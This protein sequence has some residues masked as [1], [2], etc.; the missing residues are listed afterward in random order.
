EKPLQF[1]MANGPLQTTV[2]FTETD[3]HYSFSAH[4]IPAWVSEPFD[5][6]YEET[7]LKLALAS[8]PSWEMK[9]KWA[10][11][12]NEPQFIISDTMRAKTLEIID[13][14]PDDACK[15][16]R[17]LHW[18]AEEIR[19][20]G[21]DMGEGEGHMVHPTDEIFDERIGVCKDKAA[22]LVSMLRAAGFESYFVM[23]LAM[24]RTLDIPADD[25][26]N[27]GVVAIRKDDG[28]W[29]FLDPTWAPQN[30]PLFNHLEQEQPVLIA[31]PEGVDLMH[32]PYSPPENSPFIVTAQTALHSDGSA[33]SIL[34]IETDGFIDGRFRDALNWLT[35]QEREHYIQSF[36]ADL[37]PRAIV[38]D[39]SF[40][41]PLAYDHGLQMK[42]MIHIPDA[43]R[44]LGNRLVLTPPLT[45][46]LMG[47][48]WQSDYLHADGKPE[49]RTHSLELAC[50][51]HVEFNETLKIPKGYVLSNPPDSVEING[52]TIDGSFRV[53]TPQPDQ[54]EIHQVIRIKQRVTP[55]ED[56]AE[57]QSAVK[58]LNDIRKTVFV[59]ETNGRS[60][61][62]PSPPTMKRAIR[63]AAAQMPASGAQVHDRSVIVTFDGDQLI[64]EFYKDATIYNERGRTEFSDEAFLTNVDSQEIRVLESYTLTP[65]GRRID[66]PERAINQTMTEEVLPYPAFAAMEN[67]M[68]SHIGVE[69]GGRIVTR[70]QRITRLTP[71]DSPEFYEYFFIPL[72]EFPV[73]VSRFT[74][75]I[76]ESE[77][78]H[79]ETFGVDFQPVVRQIDGM[80]ETTWEFRNM[81]AFEFERH[82]GSFTSLSPVILLTSGRLPDWNRRIDALR[83]SL[84]APPIDPSPLATT[85]EA[86]LKDAIGGSARIDALCDFISDHIAEVDLSARRVAYRLRPPDTVLA[87]GYGIDRERAALA[88]ALVEAAGGECRIGF[89]GDDGRI[90]QDVPVMLTMDAIYLD[91]LLDG[92]REIVHLDGEPVSASDWVG[93]RVLWIGRSYDFWQEPVRTGPEIDHVRMLLDMTIRSDGTADCTADFSWSGAWNTG[94][95]ARHGTDQWMKQQ[96]SGILDTPEITSLDILSLDT[97]SGT[98]RI[99]CQAG[100]GVEPDALVQNVF[101]IPIPSCPEGVANDTYTLTPGARQYPLLLDRCVNQTETIRIRIPDT[102]KIIGVPRSITIGTPP[103]AFHR[104]VLVDGSLITL[105]RE[106]SMNERRIA[107]DHYARFLEIW[108][109]IAL[110]SENGILIERDDVD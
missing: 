87:S 34:F 40:T 21:L 110:E 53:N 80:T 39:C 73:D 8:H 38:T 72:L 36:V 60:I 3:W 97:V 107:P 54:I 16:A 7:A 100:G 83:T 57:L 86:V 30:R 96:L 103:L 82:A 59:L 32:I 67:T 101:A 17:L 99:R 98:T 64:E 12:H 49:S 42:L 71:S 28:S 43:A 109:A 76:P 33:D 6:G 47:K 61:R 68:V 14:C 108:N 75:R 78:I 93:Q 62:N 66:T 65:D 41:H 37:S 5:D 91:M 70:L 88:A 44:L 48:R 25:K 4:D 58:K 13:G 45:R 92:D 74:V 77:P 89:S 79:F 20:L 27:H 105:Q 106:I 15:M 84:F 50:T 31:A 10:Y 29:I 9:S 23:T 46:H 69:Y 102:W 22:V 19:Y 63:D 18:V 85:A 81:P 2:R 11:E 35:R 51:R 90:A 1:S 55:P 26:F 56:V 95:S 52:N 24:E 94:V 104:E